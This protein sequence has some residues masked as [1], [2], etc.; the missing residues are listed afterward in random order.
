[1]PKCFFRTSYVNAVSIIALIAFNFIPNSANAAD[2][3]RGVEHDEIVVTAT[4]VPTPLERIAS[5]VTVITAEELEQKGDVF[6]IDALRNVPGMAASSSGGAAGKFTQLRIRGAEANQTLVLIDGIEVNSPNATEF[7]W[8][9]LTTDDIER[10]EI[11]RG[12]QSSLYGSDAIGGVVNIITKKG[13]GAPRVSASLEY[14]SFDTK[15]AS[16]AVRGGGD[17]EATGLGYHFSLSANVLSSNGISVA[18]ENNPISQN[19]NEQDGYKRHNIKSRLGATALDGDATLDFIVDLTR[20]DTQ[21]DDTGLDNENST[22]TWKR[23]SRVEGALSTF[24]GAWDHKT[25]VSYTSDKI[26]SFQVDKAN[27]NSLS[28]GQK[29]KFDYQ[30]TFR[31]ETPSIPEIGHQ[32]TMGYEFENEKNEQDNAFAAKNTKQFNTHSYFAQYDIDLFDRVFLGIGGRKDDRDN[33]S[34]DAE[35][36][37]LTA[38]YL[39][40]PTGTKLKG[41]LGTGQ[42]QPTFTELFGFSNNFTGNPNLKPEKSRGWDVGIEQRLMDDRLRLEATYFENDITNKIS[43]SNNTAVN[44]D[45]TKINGVELSTSFDFTSD[46][47]IGANYTFTH[48]E[49]SDGTW[50]VRRAKHIGSL[51]ANYR[52]WDDRASAN[53]NMAFNG[54]QLDQNFKRP[55]NPKERLSSYTLLSA[56]VSYD[57]HDNISVFVRGENLLN[58]DYQEVVNFNEPGIA[59]YVGIKAAF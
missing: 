32:L 34:P 48:C 50:C 44:I 15:K 24:D 13:Q 52:F 53:V 12:P 31:A 38:A 1:M 21:T 59:G 46:F 6:V 22:T 56:K 23:Y 57:V 5:S 49:E 29:A 36:W 35:T 18:P 20:S 42:K 19:N 11:L 40:R 25:G 58:E 47:S 39:H 7:Q 3:Q 14:G 17:F 9:H 8:E 54:Q 2:V 41:T 37:R 55:G 27:L 4:R 28:F 16:A 51:N 43:S 26:N 33:N 45:G 30:S 10:I